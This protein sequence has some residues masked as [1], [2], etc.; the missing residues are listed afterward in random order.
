MPGGDRFVL[1][2]LWK[3]YDLYEEQI[4]A[5]EKQIRKLAE[6]A[7]TAEAQARKLLH[8]IPGVGEVTVEAF[9]SEIGDV[10]R[11]G[12]QKKVASYAGLAPGQRESA[13][14]TKELG[15]THRGSRLLRWA[16]NQASWQLVRRDLHWRP[17]YQALARR[18]GKKKAIVAISRRLLC[19]MVAIVRSGTPYRL[20]V[21]KRP[22]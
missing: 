19:M 15:I 1:K 20:A 7:P 5:I 14:K 2:Q 17:I 16:L 9:I 6:D 3:D 22:A 18:R 12:S 21:E 10:Q 4:D 13:G 8:T 11:F